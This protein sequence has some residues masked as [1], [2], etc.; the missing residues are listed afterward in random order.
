MTE[1]PWYG[2]L[3]MKINQS[4][5]HPKVQH[6]DISCVLGGTDPGLYAWKNKDIWEGVRRR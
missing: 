1:H 6:P 4:S 3:G 5:V 2:G